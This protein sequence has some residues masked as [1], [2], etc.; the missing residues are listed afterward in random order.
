MDTRI[1]QIL[2]LAR[3]F[4]IPKENFENILQVLKENNREKEFE[5]IYKIEFAWDVEDIDE[6]A[7]YGKLVSL[8]YE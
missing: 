1:L 6:V 5:N 7:E 4:E 2:L 3:D 8:L